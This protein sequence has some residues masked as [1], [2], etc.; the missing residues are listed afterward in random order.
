MLNLTRNQILVFILV[1]VLILTTTCKEYFGNANC[2][3]IRG[4]QPENCKVMTLTECQE[5]ANNMGKD[6]EPNN[7][8]FCGVVD[9]CPIGCYV[10]SG[11]V[12]YGESTNIGE[13]NNQRVCVQNNI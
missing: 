3:D 7:D 1:V 6:F 10:H 9:T 5:W 13:C 8:V 2:S 12:Y 11:T 4:N